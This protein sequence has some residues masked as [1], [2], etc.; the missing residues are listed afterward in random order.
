VIAEEKV[1]KN[2]VEKKIKSATAEGRG[3]K[4][5]CKMQFQAHELRE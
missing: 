3:G 5:K 4:A 1:E 2:M